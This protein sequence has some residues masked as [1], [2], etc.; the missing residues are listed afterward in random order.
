MPPA[1]NCI[2]C[3][4][5]RSF[6]SSCTISYLLTFW[7]ARVCCFNGRIKKCYRKEWHILMKLSLYTILTTDNYV[8]QKYL[9]W[10]RTSWTCKWVGYPSPVAVIPSVLATLRPH[11]CVKCL[12]ARHKSGLNYLSGVN[13][14]E[15]Q[16]VTEQKQNTCF[17]NVSLG[18]SR[19]RQD[20]MFPDPGSFC[21]ARGM[22]SC[23]MSNYSAVYCAPTRYYVKQKCSQPHLPMFFGLWD[24]P[25]CVVIGSEVWR[26]WLEKVNTVGLSSTALNKE[27]MFSSV[28]VGEKEQ[29]KWKS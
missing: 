7:T 9:S 28:R 22:W 29:I 6:I 25:F 15:V 16:L 14:N 19:L 4:S 23:K 12:N 8:P 21:G 3:D 24:I 20:G 17:I 11:W 26:P 13:Y 18:K 2:D 10:S 27:G 5:K 1:S